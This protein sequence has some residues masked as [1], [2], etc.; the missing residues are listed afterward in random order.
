MFRYPP[1]PLDYPPDPLKPLKLARQTPL[2]HP[3]LGP[4]EVYFRGFG[5]VLEG[6]IWGSWGVKFQ[7]LGDLPGWLEVDFQ[8]S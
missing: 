8:G 5:G 4:V 7:V 1:T 3:N 2:N 6:Q